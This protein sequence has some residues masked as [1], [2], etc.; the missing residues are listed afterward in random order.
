[1][2]R[3]VAL[4]IVHRMVDGGHDGR[5][6]AEE[7]AKANVDYPFKDVV[8]ALAESYEVECPQAVRRAMLE[9]ALM[10]I[11][12][13]LPQLNDSNKTALNINVSN[14][15][16]VIGRGEPAGHFRAGCMSNAAFKSMEAA[17]TAVG[18]EKE[19]LY[20]RA[21]EYFEMAFNLGLSPQTVDWPVTLVGCGECQ[22]KIAPY[23][24]APEAY[25]RRAIRFEIRARE[26]GGQKWTGMWAES[27]RL[28]A[29][30][31]HAL[32]EQRENADEN[33]K[34]AAFLLH[35]SETERELPEQKPLNGV[36]MI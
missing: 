21:M 9:V 18:V 8:T 24:P 4:E 16:F 15:H 26:E 6:F 29:I 17:D 10:S 31:H 35:R 27:L 11:E 36:L 19:E 1:M 13:A 2:Y 14:A 28:Q 34:M 12:P 25:Y 32:A 5:F 30:A 20:E 23:R 33:R 7:F 22:I 3:T